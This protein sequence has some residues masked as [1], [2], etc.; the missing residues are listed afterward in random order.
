MKNVCL[1]FLLLEEAH[2]W[3]NKKTCWHDIILVHTTVRI[4]EKRKFFFP[5]N[6][7]C[8]MESF[9]LYF[10]KKKNLYSL[11]LELTLRSA[12]AAAVKLEKWWEKGRKRKKKFLMRKRMRVKV[13][14]E[15]CMGN[16]GWLLF[17]VLRK[18]DVEWWLQM[19]GIVVL[20][21]SFFEKKSSFHVFVK[22]FVFS[23]SY[24]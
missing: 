4:F 3:M 19:G 8:K 24:Y 22:V 2:E 20:F 9:F 7:F 23:L 15:M 1:S 12:A 5:S 17:C 6:V 21:F 18:V 13:N 11:R 16:G 14:V 10:E